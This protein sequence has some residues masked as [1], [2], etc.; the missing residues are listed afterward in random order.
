MKHKTGPFTKVSS[1]YTLVHNIR[2]VLLNVI[3]E[4]YGITL[5]KM[6][7]VVGKGNH[8]SLVGGSD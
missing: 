8:N 2:I 7:E 6:K 1:F 3:A 4:R 5:G